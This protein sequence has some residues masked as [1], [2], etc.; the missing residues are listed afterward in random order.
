[1]IVYKVTCMV[2]NK[3]YIGKTKRSMRERWRAHCA[4]GSGCWGLKGAIQKHG[5]DSFNTEVLADGLS[6]AAAAALEKE[7]IHVHRTKAPHGYN[8]TEGGQG[9]AHH[10]PNHG[11]NIAK[12]WRRPESRAKHMAW[13]TPERMKEMANSE[14]Q[15][16]E[17][18]RA[19]ARKRL[20]RALQMPREDALK[21]IEHTIKRNVQ[22]ARRRSRTDERIAFVQKMGEDVM[23]AVRALTSQDP[24]ASC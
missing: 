21:W 18:Q 2:N 23:A 4:K 9:S 3:A 1:M 13:R 22:H 11:E 15:W 5:K 17:Q 8:L 20:E 12:A 14:E 16:K 6:D 24:R 10:N 7:M 19:W